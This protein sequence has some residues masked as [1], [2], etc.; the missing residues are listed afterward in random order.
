MKYGWHASDLIG[1][2]YIY[3]WCFNVMSHVWALTW[4][5]KNVYFHINCYQQ[6]C[7]PSAI[8]VRD[9]LIYVLF[10][11]LLHYA[12]ISFNLFLKTKAVDVRTINFCAS[13]NIHCRFTLPSV[14]WRVL[15]RPLIQVPGLRTISCKTFLLI[16]KLKWPPKFWNLNL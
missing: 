5:V 16:A 9:S 14:C 2:N 7:S 3:T 8:L 12:T 15:D 6:L 13:L 10:L 4:I 11:S 1:A